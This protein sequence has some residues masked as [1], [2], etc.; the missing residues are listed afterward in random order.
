MAAYVDTRFRPTLWPGTP[1]PT[2]HL[3]RFAGVEV[4]GDWITWP[5]APTRGQPAA[6]LPDDFYLRELLELS[7][8]DLEGVAELFRS[9]GLF[10]DLDLRDL[11]LRS[12]EDETIQ[13]IRSYAEMQLPGDKF[14][15]TGVHRETVKLHLEKA[16]DAITTWLACQREGGLEELVAP[17][18][19]IENLTDLQEQQDPDHDPLW[20]ASLDDFRKV[21]IEIRVGD[22]ETVLQAALGRFSIGIG[23]LADRHPTIYSVS[24][25]QLYNHLAEGANVRRCANE[26]CLQH[27]VRQRGRAAYGQHRTS[28]VKYCSRECARAQA[29]RAL[30][31]RRKQNPDQSG[32]SE[33]TSNR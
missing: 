9:H 10:F 29:Q 15:R 26:T 8:D 17:D 20:P 3:R 32:K 11:D 31:R 23:D 2:P 16:Q 30:R 5:P 27:F 13:E 1:V 7:P 19:T 18:I 24:F 25:L 6:H 14:F 21:L 12:Y 4:E 28:G 22:L 33:T